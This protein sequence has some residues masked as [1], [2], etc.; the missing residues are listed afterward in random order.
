MFLWIW[1]LRN[2]KKLIGSG[3]VGIEE[4]LDLV[5]FVDDIWK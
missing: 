5:G 3:F 4:F 2:I 1:V